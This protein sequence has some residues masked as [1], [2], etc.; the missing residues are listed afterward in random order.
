MNILKFIKITIF[1]LL[2]ANVFTAS[3]FE[4]SELLNS[5]T[6]LKEKKPN[7]LIISVDDVSWFEHS[8]YGTSNVPT[9]NV[10][11]IAREGIIFNNGYVSAPSCAPARASMLSG[12]HF[13]ELEQGAFMQAFFP[14]KFVTYPQVLN[15]NGYETCS[16]GKNWGPGISPSQVGHNSRTVAGDNY[17][18]FMREDAKETKYL[19]PRDYV[20]GLKSFLSERSADKPFC[21]W[22]GIFEPHGSWMKTNEAITKTK[23]EFGI[24]VRKL[25]SDYYNA[26]GNST[27][28][29]KQK[30]GFF[31]EMLHYDRTVKM[32]LDAMEEK[33][34]LDNTMVIFIG[35]NGTFIRGDNPSGFAL[36][37]VGANQTPRGKASG[38]DAG[39]HVPFFLMWKNRTSG[40]RVVD[41][42]VSAVDIGPT[43]LDAA[44]LAIPKEMSG[45]SMMKIID[46]KASG[47][48]DASRDIMMTG[49]EHHSV[50]EL[51]PACRN[52]RDKRFEYIIHF[53]NDGEEFYDLEKDPW[54]TNNLINNPKYQSD[55]TRLKTKMKK[56]GVE[57]GDPRFT[58]DMALFNHTHEYCDEYKNAKS[59]KKWQKSFA[60]SY[61]EGLKA[62]GLPPVP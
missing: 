32:M 39:V 29:S 28:P 25:K 34:F 13:W 30:L 12:K 14:Q 53:E 40:G 37:K 49:M 16:V 24:D 44:G 42:F 19:Y 35:D 18:R 1:F 22:A 52:I 26:K 3:A 6:D 9:P 56:I 38:Y 17:N 54:E 23:S 51:L 48:I 57:Q 2:I 36:N 8:V 15:A 59:S 43:I 5:K 7:F 27:K 4:K 33:G 46:S 20:A 62:V 10:D 60:R 55:I 11:R 41:D 21:I 58:G 61:A 45:K 47:Q 50:N 31:Y